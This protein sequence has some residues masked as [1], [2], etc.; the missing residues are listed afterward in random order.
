[1]NA[2]ADGIKAKYDERPAAFAV[3]WRDKAVLTQLRG[4]NEQV[5][6]CLLMQLR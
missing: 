3:I 6:G 4:R 5:S 2:N 1:M